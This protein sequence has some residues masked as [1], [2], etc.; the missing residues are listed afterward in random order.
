MYSTP[1]LAA[2]ATE[3]AAC[4]GRMDQVATAVKAE[5]FY[6]AWCLDCHRNP[7]P[8]LRPQSE[9]TTMG[10]KAPADQAAFAARTIKELS[11]RPPTNCSGCHR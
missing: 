9:L 2:S 11:L 5:T 8:H 10:W 3:L 6:M 4:H 7:A 1:A